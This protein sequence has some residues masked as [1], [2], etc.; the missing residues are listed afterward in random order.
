MENTARVRTSR[1]GAWLERSETASLE[2]KR[3]RSHN[4]D[5]HKLLRYAALFVW[6]ALMV[7][8]WL[9][10]R[11]ADV[12]ALEYLLGV[13]DT[14]SRN[15]W[16]PAALLTLYLLRPLFLVPITL[17]NLASG[18][19]LGSWWGVAFGL[20]GVLLSSTSGY[21][22]GRF[23]GSAELGETL[24]ARWSLVR[25]LRNRG[26]EAVLA[27]GLMYLHADAVNL[28][29]GVMRI[30]FP[31]FLAGIA[32]GNA[33][34]LTTAV[35]AGASVEGGLADAAVTVDP[36]YLAVAAALFLV[37]LMLAYLVRKRVRLGGEGKN[38]KGNERV[39]ASARLT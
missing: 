23:F 24:S 25:M 35:L 20:T 32:L 30:R 39:R 1:S 5:G 18:F 21:G 13:I 19:L 36:T 28:P 16:A 31:V 34:T 27:G 37:S 9:G 11:S 33:L 26:F 2:T 29:S 6:A 14:V 7:V 12:G 3:T 10:V 17:L 4:L 22:I 15:A 8:F 38:D